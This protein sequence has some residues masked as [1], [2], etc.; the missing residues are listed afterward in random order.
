[1]ERTACF[2]QAV[3][4]SSSPPPG[5]LRFARRLFVFL[6]VRLSVVNFTAEIRACE[7]S[8]WAAKKPLHAPAYFCNPRSPPRSRSVTS[9]FA[10]SSRSIIFCHTRSAP[11]R[12]TRFSVGS[13][14]F[15]APLTLR[16]HALARIIMK[17]LPEMCLWRLRI[18]LNFVSHLL[19]GAN[20]K[21]FKNY[22]LT[23]Q[24][25]TFFCNLAHIS[26]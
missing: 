3:V 21:L 26:G 1:M 23:L 18:V 13:A 5:R 10:L 15:S 19:L 2:S 6:S 14:P 24:D 4:L 12:F 7:Q 20:L 22:F 11:L 16:S 17:L 8:A 9:R 25:R